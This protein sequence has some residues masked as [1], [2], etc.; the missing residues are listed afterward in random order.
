MQG[1]VPLDHGRG[2]AHGWG[3]GGGVVVV[4]CVCV[5]ISS[6]DYRP[7][8]VDQTLAVDLCAAVEHVFARDKVSTKDKCTECV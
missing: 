6:V 7:L 5:C 8:D 2:R 1:E 3:G 4:A